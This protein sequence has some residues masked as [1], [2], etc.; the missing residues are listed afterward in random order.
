MIKN[1]H[2]ILMVIRGIIVL[3]LFYCSS[4]FQYIPF[5]LFNVGIEPYV[6]DLDIAACLSIFSDLILILILLFIYKKDLEKEIKIFF[7]DLKKNLDTGFSCW[8]MGLI[9][10]ILSNALLVIVFHAEGANNENAVRTLVTAAPILMGINVCLLAPFIEEIVFR[11]TLKDIF[12][13][14]YLLVPIAFLLFGYAHVGMMASSLVDWLYIVPYG[15]LGG[16]FAYAYYKTNTV[17]TSMAFHMIHNT[18]TFILIL[19]IL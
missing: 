5:K 10:M 7:K 13:K 8:I 1:K 6:N 12:D 14:V 9:I 18:L 11:K 4:F 16:V 15:A 17:F 2:K 3:T 19:I